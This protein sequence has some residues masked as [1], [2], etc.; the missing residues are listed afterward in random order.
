MQCIQRKTL[1]YKTGVEYGD[2]TLN[3]VLGCSHGC[4]YPCYAFQMKKRFG[5]VSSYEEWIK[6]VVVENFIELLEKEIPKYKEKIKIL[7]LCFSTDPFMY[8]QKEVI[9]SS[10]KIVRRLSEENIPCS[11][12]TKGILPRELAN[13]SKKNEYGITIVTLDEEYRKIAEPGAASVRDRIGALR[14]LK[15]KGYKTWVS[16][17][18]FPT[19]NI[20][21]ED[22][23]DILEAVSFVDKIIFG[24][25]H[26][27]KK[28]S[29][30]NNYKEYYNQ[31][32][33][34]VISFCTQNGIEYHIKKGTISEISQK[35]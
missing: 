31:C 7:H 2:Y 29:E 19:P 27:N 20:H 14:Y 30:Y 4:K 32:A 23:M 22:L 11:I 9:D 17:E 28:V 33:E 35:S 12:L 18:P 5:K 34:K 8:E 26:Y 24:R 10:L 15:E 13:C 21:A 16:I 1:I 25:L 3:H 6:P